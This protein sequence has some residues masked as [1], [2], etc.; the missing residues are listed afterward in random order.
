MEKLQFKFQLLEG[1]DKE[2]ILCVTTITTQDGHTYK[3][4]NEYYKVEHNVDHVKTATFT[5]VKKALKRRNQ[6]RNVWKKLRSNLACCISLEIIHLFV[7]GV[8]SS[9]YLA[10]INFYR[11]WT[12][13]PYL[14]RKA[15]LSL[16]NNDFTP[17]RH[18]HKSPQI[19]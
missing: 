7:L 18:W 13:D 16:A 1:S 8:L 19:T 4:P 14:S 9:S 12:F 3:I 17:P 10:H 5:K 2:Y 11:K 15:A 6:M